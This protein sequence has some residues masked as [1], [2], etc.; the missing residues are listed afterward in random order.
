MIK[1]RDLIIIAHDLAIAVKKKN[2]WPFVLAHVKT[3]RD[4]NA[5]SHPNKKVKSISRARG[6][7]FTGIKNKL[8]QKRLVERR[9][10]SHNFIFSIL[11]GRRKGTPSIFYPLDDTLSHY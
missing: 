7:I 8:S 1:R 2:P 9:I 4:G 6:E 11:L 10:I 5:V 3:T